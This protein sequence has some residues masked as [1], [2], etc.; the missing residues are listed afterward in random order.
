MRVIRVRTTAYREEDFFL[1]TTLSDEMISSVIN[2]IIK[3][4]REGFDCYY[5]EDLFRA[6]T[7]EYPLEKIIMYN[8]LETLEI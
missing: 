2:P 1:L 6:L 5:N 3:A 8:D 7:Y 4:E